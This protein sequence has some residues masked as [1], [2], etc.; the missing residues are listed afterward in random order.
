[1]RTYAMGDPQAAFDVVMAVLAAH[2]LIEGERLAADVH[3]ISIGDHFDYDFTNPREAGA[4]GIRVLEWL[5]SH[6]PAQCT[7]L[8]GNHD[9]SRVC[10]L[11][12]IDE[13][14]FED[15]RARGAVIDREPD[16]D[17]RAKLD[18]ELIAQ[19]PALVAY[20]LPSRDF[21]S[22]S[23]AQRALVV[24]LLLAQR[25]QIA[26]TARLPDGRE[27]LITHAGVTERELQILGLRDC[28]AP[29]TIAEA[30]DTYLAR[31][32]D[33]VRD[34]WER[35]AITPL[36][37]EPLHVSGTPGC[38]GSGLLYHRPSATEKARRFHPRALPRGLVQVA[39]HTGHHKALEEL[40]PFATSAAIARA[41]GGIR[42]LAVGGD[43]TIT[44]DVGVAAPD[45]A[46]AHL[47]MIDSEM[48]RMPPGEVALLR[49]G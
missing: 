3:L 21:A 8:V 32:I 47:V 40:G 4:N 24:R 36:V 18:A 43:G 10:E 48:R 19:Y 49:L 14:S 45:E 38:E 42:T 22:F 35:A 5:A 46:A 15:A 28:R 1:M 39:G 23:A 13:A 25:M 31:A 20:G 26:T 41:R 7:I 34:A 12:E 2:D 30:L 33:D 29:R 11:A 17:V 16:R 9:I 27:A 37:L 44:Y 6:D